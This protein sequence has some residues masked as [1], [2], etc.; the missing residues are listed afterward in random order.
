MFKPS[1]MTIARLLTTR[2]CQLHDDGALYGV[3]PDPDGGYTCQA[4][5][6]FSAGDVEGIYTIRA[7]VGTGMWFR[8]KDGRVIDAFTRESV[9][10][11][12]ALY[13]IVA[14]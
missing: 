3:Q 2:I 7:G 5:F 8:L 11:D 14:E 13:D 1:S 10:P 12:P 6:G 9:D 4:V